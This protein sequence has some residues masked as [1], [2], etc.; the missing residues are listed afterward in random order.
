MKLPFLTLFLIFII[1]LTIQLKRTSRDQE[2]HEAEY[3]K[4]EHDANFVRKKNID[5]LPYIAFDISQIPL[6]DELKDVHISEYIEELSTIS[7]TKILNSTG[8]SNTDLKLEYGTANITK[9]T[10]YDNN[11]T[12]LV[13]NIARLAEKYLIHSAILLE[14]ISIAADTQE[15]KKA[16]A[17]AEL[18][19]TLKSD[20]RTLLEYGISIGT[21][22]RM[23]YE[24]LS[25]LYAEN[26]ELDKIAALKVS[27]ESL[28]SLSKAP[29]LRHLEQY[30]L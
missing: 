14:N 25:A 20:A 12:V 18:S 22:V 3:W 11:Y 23:N 5:N 24:L 8:K 21:D 27:A 29:I 13:R 16:S 1:Y 26:N 17:N 7:G 19:A 4:R 10:E 30:T 2:K 6:H 9:L 28:N 15:D